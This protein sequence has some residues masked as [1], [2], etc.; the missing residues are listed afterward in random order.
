M[1][2]LIVGDSIIRDVRSSKAVI[3]CFPGAKVDDILTELPSLMAQFP[4]ARKVV[5]HVGTNYIPRQQSELLKEDFKHLFNY[6][7]PTER[8]VFIS[9]PLPTVGH[10]CGRFSRLLQIHMWQRY[11]KTSG[12]RQGRKAKTRLRLDYD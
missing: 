6:L 12:K 4:S 10:G 9:G 11:P 1:L 2:V 3:H 8:E 7:Q 5:L